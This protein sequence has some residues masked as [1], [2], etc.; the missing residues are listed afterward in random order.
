MKLRASWCIF[1]LFFFFLYDSY[2]GEI[3]FAVGSQVNVTLKISTQSYLDRRVFLNFVI[4][5]GVGGVKSFWN[6]P[7]DRK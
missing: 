2:S 4:L 1:Y 3:I 6:Y 5:G 7:H